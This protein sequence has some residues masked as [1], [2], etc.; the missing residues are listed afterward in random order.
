MNGNGAKR[1]T[2][3]AV[4][5][6]GLMAALG[7]GLMLIGAALAVAAYAA[8]MFASMCL[9]PVIAEFGKPRAWLCYTASAVLIALLSP[10]KELAFFYVAMGY[11]PIVRSAFEAIRPKWLRVPVKLAYFA[12]VIA[13]L[14]LFLCFVLRL[15]AVLSELKKSGPWLNAVFFVLLTAVMLLY[16]LAVSVAERVYIQR[17]RPKLKFLK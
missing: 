16:D 2:A 4:T 7:V 12:A 6:C 9:I 15:D 5:F 13:L 17:I 11:Y 1:K 8:P 14:Y 10:D 3:L